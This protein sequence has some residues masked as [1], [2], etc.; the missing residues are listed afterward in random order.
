MDHYRKIL[1]RVWLHSQMP[2]DRRLSGDWLEGQVWIKP[3]TAG[4]LLIRGIWEMG[5]ERDRGQQV[6]SMID[7]DFPA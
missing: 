4:F 3:R 2:Y 6:K 1:D 5:D 7:I